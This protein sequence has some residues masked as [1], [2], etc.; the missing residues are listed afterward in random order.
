LFDQPGADLRVGHMEVAAAIPVE[1]IACPGIGVV[2]SLNSTSVRPGD[3]FTWA[4]DMSNPN[5]CVLDKVKLVDTITATPGV[6]YHVVSSDPPAKALTD[7]SV[8]FDSLGPLRQGES[9]RLTIDA[10]VDDVSAPGSLSDGAVADGVCGPDRRGTN[11][12][13]NSGPMNPPVPMSGR[14]EL[15]GPTVGALRLAG[16]LPSPTTSS[17]VGSRSATI[18]PVVLEHQRDPLARTGGVLG[19]VPA[20]MLISGGSLMRRFRRRRA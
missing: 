13:S 9:R 3:R 5:D 19:I 20:W 14:A 7:G 11:D 1:G 17:A 15:V 8:T 10:A 12:T 16:A 18:A 6:R 2:K 4:V